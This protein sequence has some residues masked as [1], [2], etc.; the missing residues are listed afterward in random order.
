[1][2]RLTSLLVVIS[3]DRSAFMLRTIQRDPEELYR[4][5]VLS[6]Y[7]NSEGW[8]LQNAEGFTAHRA[9]VKKRDVKQSGGLS[10]ND[11]PDLV[12]SQL[13]HKTPRYES[14]VT[15]LPEEA[16]IDRFDSLP[17]EA[18]SS[19]HA[20]TTT[21]KNPYTYA[22]NAVSVTPAPY[23][24][25][26]NPVPYHNVPRAP[27]YYGPSILPS[28]SS[29]TPMFGPSK[30][31]K[32]YSNYNIMHLHEPSSPPLFFGLPR[33][34]RTTPNPYHGPSTPSQYPKTKKSLPYIATPSPIAP[35]YPIHPYMPYHGSHFPLHS[36]TTTSSI[37]YP[38][39]PI[40]SYYNIHPSTNQL[41][42]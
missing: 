22:I 9:E 3:L 11:R 13:Q 28:L 38:Q 36:D 16:D 14:Y 34:R 30:S 18:Y 10:N 31:A 33:H 7:L 24:G 15:P 35:Q 19:V 40:P 23:H 42:H 2:A 32:Y 27:K 25:P 12:Y 4:S 8:F 5:H 21:T 29:P 6:H 41:Q 17:D 20:P 37:G 1:M 26:T 39:T